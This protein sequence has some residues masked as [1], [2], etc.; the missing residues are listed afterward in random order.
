MDIGWEMAVVL[1]PVF[2]YEKSFAEY[3]NIKPGEEFT[4]YKKVLQKTA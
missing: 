1:P 4:G 2:Q 3:P